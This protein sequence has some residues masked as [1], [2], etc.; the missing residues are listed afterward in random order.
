MDLDCARLD[1]QETM[2]LVLYSP[3]LFLPDQ[4]KHRLF[5]SEVCVCVR[6]HVFPRKI[7]FLLFLCFQFFAN[8]WLHLSL[9][10]VRSKFRG[11]PM[12]E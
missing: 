6:V 5:M 4:K 9:R 11:E 2:L 10:Q 3:L 1:L 12:V 8:M 7:M